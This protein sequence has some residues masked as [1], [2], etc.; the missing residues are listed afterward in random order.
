L[1][2]FLDSTLRE[3][4]LYRLFPKEINTELARLALEY[5]AD[6][7][8]LPL[9][10]R[11]SKEET[12]EL[13][14]N[15]REAKTNCLVIL[16]GR[17]SRSDIE[18]MKEFDVDGGAA[19]LSPT[20]SHRKWKLHDM[21]REEA[22]QRLMEAADML[23]SQNRKYNRV[24]IEDAS[25]LYF[26]D[27]EFLFRLLNELKQRDVIIS[28]PDTRG[29]L[30]P[31]QIESFAQDLVG[32]GAKLGGHNH[33]DFGF[34]NYN[35]AIEAANGF[36]EVHTTLMG[37]G[38]R[39]GIADPFPT[40]LI[41]ESI[42]VRSKIRIDGAERIYSEFCAFTDIDQNFKHV[43][44]K[45]SRSLSAGVHQ[46][47]PEGYFPEQKLKHSDIILRAT[48]HLS[49]KIVDR[50]LRHAGHSLETETVKALTSSIAKKS[51]ELNGD[52]TSEQIAEVVKNETGIHLDPNHISRLK[53]RRTGLSTEPHSS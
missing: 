33:D 45:E 35:T 32:T 19:Y 51:A 26:E 10:Y 2:I 18:D 3:G 17:A 4:A 6:V 39:N 1:A 28:V 40:A 13:I 25:T 30:F 49:S 29:R 31:E 41:M 8:E 5:G 34:A 43:F 37:I 48:P 21:S 53:I 50:I 23:K 42:G 24:T 36:Y 22:E 14:R 52:L 11:T 38:E 47:Y 27:R 20:S 7:L 9:P 46:T 44:S 15:V 16:H 12:C